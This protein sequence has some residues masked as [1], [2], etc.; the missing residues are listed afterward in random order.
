MFTVSAKNLDVVCSACEILLKYILNVLHVAKSEL[1][2][3]QIQQYIN[4]IQVLCI[5]K[6]YLT[7]TEYSSLVEIMKGETL[8]QNYLSTG[9][10]IFFYYINI[11]CLL[12]HCLILLYNSFKFQLFK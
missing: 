2:T 6:G 8:P 11:K 10:G 1:S 4:T 3:T 5:G 12:S 7:S 9:K